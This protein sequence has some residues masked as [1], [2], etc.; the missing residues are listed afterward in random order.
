MRVSTRGG[1]RKERKG[2][3]DRPTGLWD[4]QG[5]RLLSHFLRV[6][7]AMRFSMPVPL[8]L[9]F[10][11]DRGPSISHSRSAGLPDLPQN[12]LDDLLPVCQIQIADPLIRQVC[13]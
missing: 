10:L 8:N 11:E 4:G 2:N 9:T 3:R 5:H 7:G 6:E 13:I 1:S 12:A